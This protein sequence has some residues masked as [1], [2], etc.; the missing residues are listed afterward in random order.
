[1][2]FGKLTGIH[3][4]VKDLTVTGNVIADLV[5]GIISL[6]GFAVSISFL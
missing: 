1:M 4:D 6:I 5:L 2:R 3:N